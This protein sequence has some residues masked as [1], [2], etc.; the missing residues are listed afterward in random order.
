MAQEEVEETTPIE[1][2]VVDVACMKTAIDSRENAI[3]AALDAYHVSLKAAHESRREALK[4]AW[5]KTEKLE[6]RKALRD[7]RKA[8]KE[9]GKSARTTL[10]EARKG[11]W[12]QYK[13]DA[14]AC[15]HNASSDDG[16]AR[17]D[18]SSSL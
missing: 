5:D 15:G 11:A 2:S 6:R 13:T 16:S 3:I 4:A 7:A 1:R 8:F 12:D 14:K 9:N 18:Q 10:R 17:E